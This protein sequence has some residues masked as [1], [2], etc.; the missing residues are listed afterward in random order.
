MLRILVE[1]LPIIKS[2]GETP[3]DATGTVALPLCQSL[4]RFP[5]LFDFFFARF[6]LSCPGMHNLGVV[7][8]F[9]WIYL[10]RYWVR[11]SIAVFMGI[12]FGFTNAS[13]V[14]AA[15][16]LIERFRPA[17]EAVADADVK[18]AEAKAGK[19]KFKTPSPMASLFSG[20]KGRAK[21][22]NEKVNATLEVWLP[23][24]GRDLDWRQ[25]LGGLLFLPLLVSI[26]STTDYLSV[27]CMGWASERM[28]NDMRLDVL[29]KLSS[30]SMD[31][32]SRATSGDLLTRV[33]T[34][35]Q[36]VL[37]SLRGGASDLIKESITLVTVFAVLW[38][39]NWQLTLFALLLV[40]A[41]LFPLFILARKVRKASR[42]SIAGEVLQSSQIVELLQGIRVI[43]AYNLEKAQLDRYRE[44]SKEMVRRNMRALKAKELVNPIIEVISMFG[45]GLMIIFIFKT[46]VSISDFAGF[47]VGLIL[48]FGP[49]KKLAAV[50]MLYE[51]T[52]PGVKRLIDLL[53]ME[54]T[55]KEPANPKPLREF[56]SEVLF[57][58]VTFAYSRREIGRDLSRKKRDGAKRV[59]DDDEDTDRE[60][61]RKNR[62]A[63]ETVTEGPVI[64]DFNLVIPLGARVGIAGPSGSGKST[65]VNLLFRFYDPQ[66]GAVKIDGIDI[67]EVS[68]KDLRKQMALV[69][70]E[71]IIF[72]QSVA[73]NIACGRPGATQEEIEEAAKAAYAHDFI[74]ELPNGYK[75]RLGERGGLLSGGQRQRI[76]IARAFIR[77][78]P[79]L[80]LDEATG[81]LDSE[82]EAEVQRAIDHISENRTVICVA[83]RLSTLASCDKIIVLV[84]GRIA[85]QGSF[86]EL[87]EARGVFASMA[88]RQGIVPGKDLFARTEAV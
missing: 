37:R 57:E 67:R 38:W 27:Y 20:L 23:R 79:I 51:Q 15:K 60:Q 55:V 88:R 41:C 4:L 68:S 12:L 33:N 62:L 5:C 17:Q 31:F 52:G 11:L 47:L 7:F 13:F 25:I 22:L 34:D 40:P 26:R 10:R 53:Q 39:N 2:A 64:Q 9:G 65:L 32:F 6:H 84:D 8:G 48:F 45:V 70:Q 46:G 49:I 85:E 86:T 35:T 87:L 61:R 16:T 75:T 83:H 18:S 72:D 44:V 43:K 30:F 19:P 14:W 82:S 29:N 58:N 76:A 66:K 50:H 80:V 71:V 77:N 69:S 81:S 59:D 28:I 3:A 36:R 54:P 42:A 78:A 24:L 1:R 74:M 56:K 63:R 73:D 21:G